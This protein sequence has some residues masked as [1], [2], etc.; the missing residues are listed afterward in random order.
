MYYHGI[1]EWFGEREEGSVMRKAENLFLYREGWYL[2]Q[3]QFLKSRA[4]R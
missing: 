3:N 2:L 4:S 1:K